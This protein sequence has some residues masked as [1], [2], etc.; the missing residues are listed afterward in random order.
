MPSSSEAQTGFLHATL[1][2]LLVMSSQPEGDELVGFRN[3][4]CYVN[5]S[6]TD[7]QTLADR[8]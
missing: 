5:V 3:V 8:H 7:S 2:F 1:F 6:Q 4:L